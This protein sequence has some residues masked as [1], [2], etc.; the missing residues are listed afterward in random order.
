VLTID[1]ALVPFTG[2]TDVAPAP[3]AKGPVEV[4]TVRNGFAIV[5]PASGPTVNCICVD[6][7]PFCVS[8]V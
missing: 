2:M 4:V 6:A 7:L 8:V 5:K 1:A 3:T